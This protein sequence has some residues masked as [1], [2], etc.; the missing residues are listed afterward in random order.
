LIDE[1]LVSRGRRTAIERTAFILLHL[2]ALVEQAD[3]TNNATI[4][5][6]FTQQHLTDTLGMSLVHTDK[7][8]KRFSASNAIR[9][10]R[11][12]ELV[13]RARF[14]AIAGDDAGQH[15]PRPFI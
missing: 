14:V 7:T 3:L 2:F 9:W 5:I 1:N 4:Q 11:M 10:D 6:P 15:R 8:L 12:F 13:D